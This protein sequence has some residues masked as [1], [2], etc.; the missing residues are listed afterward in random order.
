M[1]WATKVYLFS[2]KENTKKKTENYL[3]NSMPSVIQNEK[4]IQLKYR[5][6]HVFTLFEKKA[7]RTY[8]N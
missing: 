2:L 6:T 4:R 1:V 3:S 5:A 7:F 8:I